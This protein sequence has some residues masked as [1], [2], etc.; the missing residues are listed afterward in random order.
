MVPDVQSPRNLAQ[1]LR[2]DTVYTISRV[3]HGLRQLALVPPLIVL[4]PHCHSLL[5][6]KDKT[7]YK[8]RSYGGRLHQIM[9]DS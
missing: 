5:E 4:I 2:N 7:K 8:K 6:E 3:N 1:P 9:V